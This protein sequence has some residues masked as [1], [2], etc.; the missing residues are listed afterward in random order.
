MVA[1]GALCACPVSLGSEQ[2]RRLGV[3][4]I[5]LGIIEPTCRAHKRDG[6]GKRSRRALTHLGAMYFLWALG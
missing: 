5:L 6:G 4:G 1:R 3:R 2:K